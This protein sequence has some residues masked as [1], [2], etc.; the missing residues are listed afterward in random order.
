M[1]HPPL[2]TTLGLLM[3]RDFTPP[4]ILLHMYAAILQTALPKSPN[5]AWV[6]RAKAIVDA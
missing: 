4:N 3:E 5:M 6:Q 2:D 1:W